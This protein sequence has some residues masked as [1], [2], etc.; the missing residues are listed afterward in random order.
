MSVLKLLDSVELSGSNDI[1]VSSIGEFK[2]SFS[3]PP[4]KVATHLYSLLSLSDTEEQRYLIY[5]FIFKKY[6]L[7]KYDATENGNLPAGIISSI[8]GLILSFSGFSPNGISE[9]IEYLDIYRSTLDNSDVFMKRVIC[10]VFPSYNF[11]KLEKLS[12]QEI[13]FIFANAEKCQLE[14]KEI[15]KPYKFSK[16]KDFSIDDMVKKEMNKFNSE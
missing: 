9:T 8:A 10:S 14:R 13:L 3:L 7:D 16:R 1:Y 4:V 2:I 6:V 5:N 11:K 15:E 12:F